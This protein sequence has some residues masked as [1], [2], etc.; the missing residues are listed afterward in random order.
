M[1]A[2]RKASITKATMAK[3]AVAERKLGRLAAKQAK[4]NATQDSYQNA[5][6]K[7]GLGT[8]NPLS[9]STYGFNPITRIRTLLEWIYRGGWLGSIAVDIVADDMTRA[10]IEINSEMDPEAQD[11]LR[12]AEIE[13]NFW[14]SVN[15]T[16]KW[17]RLYGGAIMVALIDGQDLAT[18]YRE[19]IP[20]MPGQLKGFLVLDKWMVEAR[21][22][23]LVSEYGPELGLP[24]FYR[25]S[26]DAP[27]LRG[28]N[29]HH[30][31]VL[32]MAGMDLPYW[33]RVQENLWG[34]SVFERLYDRMVALD[35]STQGAAQL[36]YKSFLRTYKLKGLTDLLSSGGDAGI[37]TVM[38]KMDM[39]RRYQSNEGLTVVDGEDDITTQ[40]NGSFAGI[41][42]V[43]LQIAQQISGTLQIPLVRMFGQSPAGLNSTG[44]ADLRTY[45]DGIN[46]QQERTMRRPVEK[47]LR[48]IAQS[49]SI[50]LP[51]DFNWSF[52]PL[53][54]LDEGQ[55]SEISARDATSIAEMVEAQLIDKPT[56][57]K[58]LKQ[59]SRVTGRFDNITDEAIKAAELEPADMGLPGMGLS[60]DEII[61]AGGDPTKV[62]HDNPANKPPPMPSEK[63]V[64]PGANASPG[65]TGNTLKPT[66]D[67]RR[68]AYDALP[69]YHVCGVQVSIENMMGTIREGPGW[70]VQM[71]ADYGHIPCVDSA[72]GPMEWM[73]AF[74]GPERSSE[75]VWIV[76]SVD[77]RTGKFDEHKCMLGFTSEADARSCF[78]ANYHDDAVRRIG[79]IT[80]M[81][82]DKFQAWLRSG[83]HTRAVMK[84][85]A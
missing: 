64:K 3:A 25:V 58:E 68:R 49:K 43:I 47:M 38:R 76:D 57:M 18:P 21:L 52:R 45:Y 82:K 26:S 54:Q 15:E 59:Q 31:R 74:V 56:G 16:V 83:D 50:I 62:R 77:P 66:K 10:G 42:D 30:S 71:T 20:L 24:M 1:A 80:H 7:L 55:K 78:E 65:S 11:K 33:Q 27:A 37:A 61:A 73:D 19:D 35:S 44:E 67:Q 81:N 63:G 9:A 4:S 34:L 69:A 60:D 22:E 48:M 53:W 72:E 6:L 36:V 29:I 28:K 84:R 17:S 51:K 14:G 32:R 12:K 70:R 85:A 5:M 40:T 2:S 8:D 46:T 13:Y 79:G 39:V 23:Q 41:S 75:D